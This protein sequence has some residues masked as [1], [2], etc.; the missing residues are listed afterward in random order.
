[1]HQTDNGSGSTPAAANAARPA[2]VARLEALLAALGRVGVA[3]SGGVDS[4]YL[5][6]VAVSVLGPEKAT[7]F[8]AVSPSLPGDEL[9]AAHAT[10]ASVGAPLLEVTTPRWAT[11]ATARTTRVVATTA[12]RISTQR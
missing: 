12:S 11:P 10:A 4:A 5:L 2:K 7:A 1:M 9:A 6:A 3:F 8:I